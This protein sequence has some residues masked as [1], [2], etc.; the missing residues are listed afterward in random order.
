MKKNYYD[1]LGVKPTVN[2]QAIK[3]AYRK[4]SKKI[5]PD[6]NG[7]DK[8]FEDY[9]KNI[10]EAYEILSNDN[11]R[12][13][14]DTSNG[15]Q[16]D[17][18]EAELNNLRQ[19]IFNLENRIKDL[20]AK[21]R[22]ITADRNSIK[23]ELENYKQNYFESKS[24]EGSLNNR[25]RELESR[26][27]NYQ[28][29]SK[30]EEEETNW[31]AWILGGLLAFLWF[32]GFI[33]LNQANSKNEIA[34]LKSQRE[35]LRSVISNNKAKVDSFNTALIST[36]QELSVI[37]SKLSKISSGSPFLIESIAFYT[38]K[39]TNN[40]KTR[41]S[42]GE[43]D[44]IY[45]YI[46]IVP[47]VDSYKSLKVYV[48]IFDPNG[49][50]NYNSQESPKGYTFSNDVTVSYLDSHIELSGWGNK[51]RDAYELGTHKVQIWAN[52]KLLGEGKFDVY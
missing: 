22:D 27:T 42:Y 6:V 48:K 16:S 25:V 11:S 1:I 19:H 31:P 45:P 9:F 38:S 50:L 7:S 3:E 26:P 33:D 47:L 49:I 17:I 30:S 46:K 20:N 23:Y 35:N 28:T 44:Y 2:Q 4:L 21:L 8:Y 24:R 13:N 36:K 32:F 41:F 37:K 39:N 43:I 29:P 40:Y 10:Q 18:D 15:G 5:H 52:G 12:R 34:D 14:Y 51:T